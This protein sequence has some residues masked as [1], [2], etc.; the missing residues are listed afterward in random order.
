MQRNTWKEIQQIHD[1][2][3]NL[4]NN[5]DFGSSGLTEECRETCRNI[6]CFT[7]IELDV[8]IR[9]TN[10]EQDNVFEKGVENYEYEYEIIYRHTNASK[11]TK[12]IQ[13]IY[14]NRLAYGITTILP[15][16]WRH[17]IFGLQLNDALYNCSPEDDQCQ[18]NWAHEWIKGREIRNTTYLHG[19]LVPW[20]GLLQ[21]LTGMNV[22][23]PI[24][25]G[26]G[27]RCPQ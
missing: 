20:G 2:G 27:L 10:M 25:G 16:E 19:A 14:F 24:R 1:G 13:R 15:F 7:V 21:L 9:E 12:H 26:L 23:P 11:L 4:R 22:P 8:E 17:R 3:Y 18:C 6:T 5:G